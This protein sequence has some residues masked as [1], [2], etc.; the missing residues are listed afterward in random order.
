MWQQ[1]NYRWNTFKRDME[2][3]RE[4][5]KYENLLI[6]SNYVTKAEA[7]R[8]YHS[9]NDVAEAKYLYVPFFAISDSAITVTDSDLRAYYN[10]TKARYKA[11]QMRNL[12]YVAFSIEA[13]ASDSLQI[14]ED[15]KTLAEGFKTL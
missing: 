4:R 7:E 11:E 10:R 2:L 5:I 9:Q 15:L 8:D 3:G 14:R 1:G 6:K 13:S 12:N